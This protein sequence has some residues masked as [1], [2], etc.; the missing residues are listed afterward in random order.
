M[1]VVTPQIIKEQRLATCNECDKKGFIPITNVAICT[2]CNCVLEVKTK[3]FTVKCP[4]QKWE[5]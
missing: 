1:K 3:F 4:L 2:E 5:K